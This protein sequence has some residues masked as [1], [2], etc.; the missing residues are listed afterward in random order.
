MDMS[1]PR[2]S[3]HYY[4][5]VLIMNICLNKLDKFELMLLQILLLFAI[6]VI[7][8][9]VSMT[10]ELWARTNI[11]PISKRTFIDNKSLLE[12]KYTMTKHKM[13]HLKTKQ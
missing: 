3:D 10:P 2:I 1:N 6:R 13:K 7:H 12:I 9:N 4:P 8:P 11:G 5:F